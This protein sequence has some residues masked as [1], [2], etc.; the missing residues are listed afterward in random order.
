MCCVYSLPGRSGNAT[1]TSDNPIILLSTLWLFNSFSSLYHLP[2][3]I[4][5][6][7]DVQFHLLSPIK[8]LF[9]SFNIMIVLFHCVSFSFIS[10]VIQNV[11]QKPSLSDPDSDE[12]AD[13]V[14]SLETETGLLTNHHTKGELK[15]RSP[16]APVLWRVHRDSGRREWRELN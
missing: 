13:L 7:V 14:L 1:N 3:H 5:V 16:P 8:S 6:I 11:E 4:V 12:E 9:H 2:S 10:S 15:I